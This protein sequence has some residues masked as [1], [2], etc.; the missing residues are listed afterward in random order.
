MSSSGRSI[1]T[2]TNTW[3]YIVIDP[4]AERQQQL[5]TYN[6]IVTEATGTDSSAPARCPCGQEPHTRIIR[7]TVIF[8]VKDVF[9]H[10]GGTE[11][12]QIENKQN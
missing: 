11:D 3:C 2:S 6:R 1:A 12:W 8:E 7:R 10:E 4:A 9:W 5:R